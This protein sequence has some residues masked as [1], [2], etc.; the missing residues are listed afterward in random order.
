MAPFRRG[1][2]SLDILGQAL[3]QILRHQAPSPFIF[4]GKQLRNLPQ[5]DISR[6][7]GQFFHGPFP[8]RKFRRQC[9]EDVLLRH[10]THRFQHFGFVISTTRLG[11]SRDQF[12]SDFR[13]HNDNG[14]LLPGNRGV[15]LFRQYCRDTMIEPATL[16]PTIPFYLVHFRKVPAKEVSLRHAST[17]FSICWIRS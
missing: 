16:L 1:A 6:L 12:L 9:L 14:G 7:Q 13:K 15:P 8:S 5:H 2:I 17:K 3:L 10:L 4:L 11:Q